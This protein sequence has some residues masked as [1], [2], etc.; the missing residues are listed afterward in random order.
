M[1]G[2][3]HLSQGKSAMGV[4]CCSLTIVPTPVKYESH[5]THEWWMPQEA[6]ARQQQ[7]KV[8]GKPLEQDSGETTAII[9]KSNSVRKRCFPLLAYQRQILGTGVVLSVAFVAEKWVV[10]AHQGNFQETCTCISDPLIF[11]CHA[12]SALRKRFCLAY[13]IWYVTMLAGYQRSNS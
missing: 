12:D 2:G 11:L 8:T 10:S 13:G 7:T 6:I 3:Y 4:K 9:V 5:N 1:Q